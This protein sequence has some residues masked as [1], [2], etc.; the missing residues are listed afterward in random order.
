MSCPGTVRPR[1]RSPRTIGRVFPSQ[2]FCICRWIARYSRESGAVVAFSRVKDAN[3]VLRGRSWS[4]EDRSLRPGLTH[5]AVLYTLYTLL[6]TSR[7][8]ALPYCLFSVPLLCRQY[9][10]H[11]GIVA[12]ATE[13][14]PPTT[15]HVRYGRKNEMPSTKRLSGRSLAASRQPPNLCQCPHPPTPEANT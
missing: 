8:S 13:L 4:L 5:S 2:I 7:P 12:A 9:D 11:R 3:R 6:D 1:R 10:G 15:M 14:M